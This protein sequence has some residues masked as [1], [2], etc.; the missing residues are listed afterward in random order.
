MTPLEVPHALLNLVL[1]VVVFFL[2]NVIGGLVSPFRSLN[3]RDLT[4][5]WWEGYNCRIKEEAQKITPRIS[6]GRAKTL[7]KD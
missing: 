2:G 4:A 5:A 6:D 7:R 1:M 3:Q